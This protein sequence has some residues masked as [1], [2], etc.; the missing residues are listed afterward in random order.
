MSNKF[1][2]Q[3]SNGYKINVDWNEL[4]W[5]PCCYYSKRTNLL[6][7][8]AFKKAMEYTSNATDWL[9]ECNIC[10]NM[11]QSNVSTLKPRLNSFRRIPED[12]ENGACVDLEISFDINCNAACLSCSGGCSTAWQKYNTK[13]NLFDYGLK[14]DDP[15]ERFL[16]E[17][18]DTVPLD[19]LR[20]LFILGGE[21][22]YSDTQLKFIKHVIQ[23][24]P[25]VN[26]LTLQYSTNG[27]LF[28]NE[29]TISLWSKFKTVQI[30]MSLDGIHDKFNYLRWPLTW[31]RV[32]QTVSRFLNETSAILNINATVSP[33][34]I[35]YFQEIE[36]WVYQTIP[37]ERL[38][39]PDFPV[40]VNS[41]YDPLP[42]DVVNEELRQACIEKYG[43][44][45][46]ISQIL[47]KSFCNVRPNPIKEKKMF[48]YIKQHDGLRHL[49][50]RETFPDLVEYYPNV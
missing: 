5:A 25:A 37:K 16:K 27:S 41:C 23:V 3:L 28:P 26:E 11:E 20:H 17:L 14:F 9:P 44:N 49:N 39:W 7:Q 34:N 21:P 48:D 8:D 50:W 6:D 15:A 1:C 46:D 19:R 13:H 35:L 38:R 31:D 12:V 18:I 2:R 33:L 42:L 45:H 22:F 40:R 43:L 47:K 30:S 10:R 36:D 32:E 4:S 29:E 24:H